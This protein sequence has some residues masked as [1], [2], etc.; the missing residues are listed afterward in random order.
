MERSISEQTGSD[1]PMQT[2]SKSP[3]SISTGVAFEPISR[4]CPAPNSAAFQWLLGDNWEAPDIISHHGSFL[5][6]DDEAVPFRLWGP[7][8]EPRACIVLLHGACDY[9]AAFDELGPALAA[10]G[11]IAFAYDQRG[12]GVR[13]SRGLSLQPRRQ[14]ADVSAA[15]TAILENTEDIYGR[16]PS[17]ARPFLLGES[18]GGGIAICAAA[19]G[20]KLAGAVLVS[21][22]SLACL[23]RRI[24]F[25]FAANLL[26][27]VAPSSQWRIDRRTDA[28]LSD[29]AAIRLLSDPLVLR[30]VPTRLLAQLFSLAANTARNGARIDIPTLTLLGTHDRVLS[31]DCVETL[32]RRFR[33]NKTL[34]WVPGAT[35]FL[36]HERG[37]NSVFDVISSWILRHAAHPY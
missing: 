13:R 27:V 32:H 34:H 11:I 17:C 14:L 15:C 12:F 10:H 24:A 30:H 20:L 9:S 4:S 28:N 29:I 6:G 35:H 16:T 18:M 23:Y 1:V 36:L 33:G 25:Q 21:P 3:E 5:S 8:L 2:I 7:Q 19:N 31:R 37:N 26:S 22:A